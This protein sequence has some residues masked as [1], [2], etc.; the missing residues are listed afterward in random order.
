VLRREVKV[1]VGG[2]NSFNAT[3]SKATDQVMAGGSGGEIFLQAPNGTSKD[4]ARSL[5]QGWKG[6]G[7]LSRDQQA[8]RLGWYRSIKLTMVDQSGIV[9]LHEP[10]ELPPLRT[11]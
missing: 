1:W 5:V 8:A 10:L 6:G 9:L 7:G 11:K 3:M 4:S 2:K